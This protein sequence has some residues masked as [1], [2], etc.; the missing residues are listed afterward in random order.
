MSIFKG[1]LSELYWMMQRRSV[2]ER[3]V[4]AKSRKHSRLAA[5][6]R[7]LLI[8]GMLLPGGMFAVL[9]P[10]QVAYAQS[11]FICEAAPGGNGA[12]QIMGVVEQMERQ[13]V[14]VSMDREVEMLP[15]EDR[16]IV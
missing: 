15:Q 14:A 1:F 8:A 7:L 13:E 10:C 12:W 5:W 16:M 2:L 4:R 6:K 9:V 3:L 11:P